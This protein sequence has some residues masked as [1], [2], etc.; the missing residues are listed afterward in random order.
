[1][2]LLYASAKECFVLATQAVDLVQGKSLE[3]RLHLT[4][5]LNFLLQVSQSLIHL[6]PDQASQLLLHLFLHQALEL[7]PRREELSL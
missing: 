5:L 2:D 6:V 7:L 4:A 3:P 1:V